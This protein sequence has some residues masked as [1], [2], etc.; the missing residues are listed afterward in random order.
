MAQRQPTVL[1]LIYVHV[2]DATCSL[3]QLQCPHLKVTELRG[4]MSTAGDSQVNVFSATRRQLTMRPVDPHVL[5]PWF[6]PV[7][8]MRAVWL[9]VHPCLYSYVSVGPLRPSGKETPQPL[10]MN[11]D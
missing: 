11:Q 1:R 3:W 9:R 10:P 4:N 7:C 8:L 2:I 6:P 5:L